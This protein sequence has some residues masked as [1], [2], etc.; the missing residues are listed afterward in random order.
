MVIALKHAGPE[1]HVTVTLRRR[2]GAF[3]FEIADDGLGMKAREAAEGFGMMSMKD[4]VGAV[5]G[6]VEVHLRVRRGHL[7][8]GNDSGRLSSIV[9][10][11]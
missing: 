5:G 6:E 11:G 4:R 7:R 8:S 2:N 3:E 10:F 1:V 9:R